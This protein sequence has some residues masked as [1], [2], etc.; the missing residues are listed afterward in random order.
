[1]VVFLQEFIISTGAGWWREVRKQIQV[2]LGI[3]HYK[4]NGDND[5][6]VNNDDDYND[7]N[8]DK[9]NDE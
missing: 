7:D 3:K 5:F 1:M 8:A 2:C 9:D 4:A 6:D